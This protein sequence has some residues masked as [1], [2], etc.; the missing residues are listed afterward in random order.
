MLSDE[1]GLTAKFQGIKI[2][3]FISDSLSQRELQG[4][5]LSKDFANEKER[6]TRLEKFFLKLLR[7]RH[8]GIKKRISKLT[9]Q[10]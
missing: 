9:S 10:R 7:N 6:L 1:F 8:V 4:L 3:D 2:E 5:L